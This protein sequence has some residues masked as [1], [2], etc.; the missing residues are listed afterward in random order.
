MAATATAIAMTA[1]LISQWV[2]SAYVHREHWKSLNPSGY[3]FEGLRKD[4][5]TVEKTINAASAMRGD[6]AVLSE[7]DLATIR[8]CFGRM[9]QEDAKVRK[10]IA[11]AKLDAAYDGRNAMLRASWSNLT[12]SIEE[13]GQAAE[14]SGVPTRWPETVEEWVEQAKLETALRSKVGFGRTANV[15]ASAVSAD[16]EAQSPAP[17]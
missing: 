16:T 5:D 4:A 6:E 1:G 12:G 3:G 11:R 8:D 7:D 9:L 17:I 10:E 15:Q 2:L 13:S 14:A